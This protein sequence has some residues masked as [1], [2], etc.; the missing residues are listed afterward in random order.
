MQA[1]AYYLEGRGAFHLGVRG[2]GLEATSVS[3]PADTLFAALCHAL[4]QTY[5]AG[6]LERFLAT[7]PRYGQAEPEGEPALVLSS[8]FPYAPTHPAGANAAPL[9]D[10]IAPDRVLRLW[11]RPLE[12]P[13]MSQSADDDHKKVKK[14]AWLSDKLLGA[15]LRG[16]DLQAEW[17]PLP[18]EQG[19]SNIVQG[20]AVWLGRSELPLAQGWRDA[21]SDDIAFW[22]VGDAPRVTVD[23]ASSASAVYQAGR[24]RF[25]PGGGLWFLARWR[26]DEWR[27]RGEAALTALGD[28][29]LGGERSVGHG[30]FRLRRGEAAAPWLG[31]QAGERIVTLSLYYPRE[32]EM[33]FALGHADARYRLETR[34]GWMSSP[35]STTD[36]KETYQGMAL[37]RK[38]VRMVAE[39]S[40]LRAPGDRGYVGQLADVT[41]EVFRPDVH[42]G[43][44]L[45]W[46]Y[47]VALVAGYGRRE[48]EACDG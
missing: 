41:P 30:Q 13:A 20:G 34:R 7:Y 12:A 10:P 26:D 40:I 9:G 29:G 21:E 47:G 36:G 18:S 37:R 24:V 11:P 1:T 45:V 48:E 27:Q 3:C 35:D 38:A 22:A 46:R 19:E 15:W 2:V 33:P 6:E 17:P 16:D 8:A 42:P 4:R 14:I 5:G 43:G 23:R 39:G 25:Q 44:H 32:C 28:A 31:A